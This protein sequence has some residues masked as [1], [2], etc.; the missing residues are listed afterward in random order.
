VQ[1]S[2]SSDGVSLRR[3]QGVDVAPGSEPLVVKRWPQARVS[4]LLA[5]FG[6]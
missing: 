3:G 2:A 5:R 4:A 6:R 1:R